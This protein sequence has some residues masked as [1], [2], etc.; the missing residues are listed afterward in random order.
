M[1]TP[2]LT[3][4]AVAGWLAL[5]LL[6]R[7]IALRWLTIGPGGDPVF[8]LL[9]HTFRLYLRIM[10]RPTYTGLEHVPPSNDPG[11]LIVVSNHTGPVDPLLIQ[12]GC[13]FEIRWMM[14]ENMMIRQLDWLWQ[15][16]WIIPVARDG[17][18]LGPAREAIRHVRDG[19]VVGIFPEGGIARPAGEIRPF[20]QGVGLI[21]S[22]T[23]APVLLVWVSDTPE[24]TDIGPAFMSR[25]HSRVTFIGRVDFA[26]KRDSAS[27]TAELRQR[28]A[29]ASGWTLN[30]EPLDTMGSG[31]VSG[32]PTSTTQ[33][34]VP[35]E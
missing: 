4:I 15:Q 30:D 12:A 20:Y 32:L 25:S 33:P 2:V 3:A 27:I 28:L 35:R 7:W 26:G 19:G 34:A 13:R 14:A 5:V 6:F 17:S 23:K 18:D 11:G 9:W 31:V 16:Q 29:D 22:R 24:A 1:S 10:H 8:G 21:V